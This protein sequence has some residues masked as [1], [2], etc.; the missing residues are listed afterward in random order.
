MTDEPAGP[1]VLALSAL[2]IGSVALAV[3]LRRQLRRETGD[4]GR[5]ADGEETTE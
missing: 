1:W 5:A 2:A 3:E 4:G